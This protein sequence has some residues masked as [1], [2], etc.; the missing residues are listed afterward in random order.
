MDVAIPP[1][2]RPIKRTVKFDECLVMQEIIYST[3]KAR[4][5]FFRPLFQFIISTIDL[6]K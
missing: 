4:Q 5:T 2:S 6:I 3:T 1:V